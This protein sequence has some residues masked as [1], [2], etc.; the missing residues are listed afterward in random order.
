MNKLILAL[1]LIAA[2]IALIVYGTRRA[3]SVTGIA[4]EVGAKLA[5]KWDGQT[6]QPDH[7]WYYA[8]GGALILAG[9]AAAL[10]KSPGA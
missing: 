3:D 7:V 8:G 5:N 9:V 4:D 1:L 10:R 6:R 2:G